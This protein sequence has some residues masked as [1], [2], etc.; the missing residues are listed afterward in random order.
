MKRIALHRVCGVGD[1]AQLTPLLRQ[2]RD[3]FPQAHVT[4]F[5]SENAAPVLR[6]APWIDELVSL[7]KST[8]TPGWQNPALIRMWWQ[9]A[10][11]GRFD[12][13]LH[14]G[15]RWRHAI[16]SVCVRAK[17]RA[18]LST[19]S[20]RLPQPFQIIEA[21]PADPLQDQKHASQHYLDLWCRVTGRSDRGHAAA[22]PHL[23]L[24]TDVSRWNL[25]SCSIAIAPG[26]GNWLNP[27]L[28]KRW[29]PSHWREFMQ[30]AIAEGFTPVL[31]GVRGDFPPEQTPHE[32]LS[33]LGDAT[34]EETAAVLRRCCGFAGHDSGLFHLALALGVPSAAFFGPTRPEL[35]GPFRQP[36]S[37]V[38]RHPLPCAPCCSDVC[39]RPD[40]ASLAVEG[41]PLCLSS[42]SPA[43]AWQQFKAFLPS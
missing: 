16:G 30:K 25:P 22:L 31:L 39:L 21:V 10:T 2:M 28:S 29:P 12:L 37:L 40:A 15:A 5:I 20:S 4:C 36:H 14:L 41:S 17:V 7:P 1:A 38:L 13:F 32:A 43:S 6:G 24:T 11:Q 34:L 23:G 3:D 27:A 18:G 26:S 8:V 19:A 9:I 42:I 33:L 35:T